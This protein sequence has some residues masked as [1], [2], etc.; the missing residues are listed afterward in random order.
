M[1]HSDFAPHLRRN[2]AIGELLRM[3][4][5]VIRDG[6]VTDL[7]AEFLRFWMDQH[8]DLLGLPPLDRMAPAL[9]R[10]IDGEAQLDPGARESLF[11]LLEEV[12]GEYDATGG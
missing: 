12:A 7:E 4:R 2:Q 1:S 8:P 9:R 11:R 10:L 3:V 5:A 6:K